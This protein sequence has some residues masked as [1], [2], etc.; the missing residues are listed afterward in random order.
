MQDQYQKKRDKTCENLAV[1]WK[2]YKS[3]CNQEAKQ[4]A[5]SFLYSHPQ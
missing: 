4:A 2:K 5:I 3:S 1:I